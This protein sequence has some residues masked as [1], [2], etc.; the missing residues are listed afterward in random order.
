MPAR[1]LS[2]HKSQATKEIALL[3]AAGRQA[4]VPDERT[5]ARVI[6]DAVDTYG[7]RDEAN[8]A[9]TIAEMDDVFNI[10]GNGQQRRVKVNLTGFEKAGEYQYP[11]GR[12]MDH[13]F[14][15]R[16]G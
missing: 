5:S 2:A 13:E 16:R 7:K 9:G 10:T 15:L 14:I 11:V 4:V 12:W 6:R 8:F 3:I 1:R